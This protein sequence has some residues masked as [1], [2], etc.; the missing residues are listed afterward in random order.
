VVIRDGA[1]L[2]MQSGARFGKSSK[3]K[4]FNL[5]TKSKTD[6]KS[7]GNSGDLFFWSIV[8]ASVQWIERVETAERGLRAKSIVLL[9]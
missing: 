4:T 6:S 3:I 2:L 7:S 8:R 9:Q 5:L 1:K